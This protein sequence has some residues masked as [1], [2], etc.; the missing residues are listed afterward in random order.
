MFSVGWSEI[1]II[2]VVALVV[3]GPKELPEAMRSLGKIVNKTRRLLGYYRSQFDEVIKE[4]EL[5]ELRKEF[6]ELKK[7]TQELNPINLMKNE[8]EGIDKTLSEHD[9]KKVI[10][11][12]I[13]DKAELKETVEF[14]SDEAPRTNYLSSGELLLK[15]ENDKLVDHT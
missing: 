7:S 9:G 5:S 1:V 14:K 4:S 13:K 11:T 3:I 2:G 15:D 6:V 10:N 12:Q 8:L